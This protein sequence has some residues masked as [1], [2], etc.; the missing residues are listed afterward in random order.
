MQLFCTCTV[1]SSSRHVKFPFF[2][3]LCGPVPGR[4]Q[5][6]CTAGKGKLRSECLACPS[7]NSISSWH[8]NF[9]WSYSTLHRFTSCQAGTA[10]H[11]SR[12]TVSCHENMCASF[13]RSSDGATF[14]ADA[15]PFGPVCSLGI[16]FSFLLLAT[17][18][19][20]RFLV[21]VGANA[22]AQNDRYFGLTRAHCRVC[23]LIIMVI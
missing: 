5:Q 12:N 8:V 7:S 18:N 9:R 4:H 1:Q 17:N 20:W 13:R 21:W 2:F 3:V 15:G 19:D 22:P 10:G 6:Y 11:D 16:S 23:A 14:V